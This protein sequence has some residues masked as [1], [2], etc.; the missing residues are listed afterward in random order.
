MTVEEVVGRLEVQMDHHE[1]DLGEP[2]LVWNNQ[3]C[4]GTDWF[5]DA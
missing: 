1:L 4:H 2:F 3:Y 5:H